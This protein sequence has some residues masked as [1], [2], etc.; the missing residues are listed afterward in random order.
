MNLNKPKLFYIICLYFSLVYIL[1]FFLVTEVV[2]EGEET[3]AKKAD[4]V[5][6]K[7]ADNNA[8]TNSVTR[9]V[10]ILPNLSSI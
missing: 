7:K 4:K 3:E 10:V 1:L 6:T 2:W 5:T 8:S 9:L